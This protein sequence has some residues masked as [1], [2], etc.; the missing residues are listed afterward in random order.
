[1]KTL[2]HS[3]QNIITKLKTNKVTE[4]ITLIKII[5]NAGISKDELLKYATFNHCKT[6]SYGRNTL[7]QDKNFGIYIM[8]WAPGDFTG[9]HSHGH[10]EWGVV[11]SLGDADHRTYKVNGNKVELETSEIIP[12]GT[13]APVCGD[14]VHAMGNLSDKSFLTL[15]IYGS[16]SYSGVITEDSKLYEIEKDRIRTTVG[17]AYLNISDTFCKKDVQGIETCKKTKDDYY[18][19]INST[20][21][22]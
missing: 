15:H 16:N 1:M 2:P 14:L 13:A 10:S 21:L 6:E 22:S 11:Y 3:I 19:L 7:Y 9:I 20:L 4:N 18:K 8:S 5:E 17:P 12:E